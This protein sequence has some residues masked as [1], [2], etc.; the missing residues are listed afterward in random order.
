M[1]PMIRWG[2]VLLIAGC[3]ARPEMCTPR[4]EGAPFCVPDSGR[5]ANIDVQLQLKDGCV[6]SCDDGVVSCV[7]RF[8]GGTTIGLALVGTSCS[9]PGAVCTTVC[10]IKTYPC[11]LPA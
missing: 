5:A 9:V 1:R 4:N 11:A 10:G 8:D 3:S 7:V 2:P 6:G